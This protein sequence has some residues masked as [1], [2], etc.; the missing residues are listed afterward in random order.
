MYKDSLATDY[1]LLSH[2][3]PLSHN[4][5]DEGNKEDTNKVFIKS[6]HHSEVQVSLYLSSEILS[7]IHV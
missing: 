7:D 4:K 3:F 5:W 2:Q 1:S 6:F